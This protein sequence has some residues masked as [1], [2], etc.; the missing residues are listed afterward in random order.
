VWQGLRLAPDT[1]VDDAIAAYER[2]LPAGLQVNVQRSDVQHARVQRAVRPVVVALTAF[3]LAA[4]LAA[5]A[6]GALGI[7]RL[8]A[9]ARG[10]VRTL[11]ALGLRPA[12]SA[13]VL[14][15]GAVV[16]AIAGSSG[17]VALA[18]ALSPLGPVGPVRRVEPDRGLDLDPTV[19]LFGG[20]LLVAVLALVALVAARQ[21]VAV[22]RIDQEAAARPSRFVTRFAALGF[23]PAAVVGARHAL[24]DGRRG[25]PPARSTIAACTVAVAAI[26]ASLT[27]GASVRSLLETPAHYGWA[28]SVAVQSGGGYD[29][30]SLRAAPEVARLE[31]IEGITIAGFAPIDV[32]GDRI[33]AIGIVPVEGDPA[34]S[35]VRGR[36]PRTGHEVALG[37]STAR[38][39]GVGVG[40]EIPA[41][42]GRLRVTGIVALPAIG[43]LA[44]AHPSLGQGALLTL[45][46]LTA[47]DASTYPSLAFL[48]LADGRDPLGSGRSTV[49]AAYAALS[50]Y[51]AAGAE[52][53][54][55]MRPAEVLGLRP[56]SRTANLLAGLLAAAAILALALSLTASVRRRAATYAILSSLGFARREIRRTVRWHTNLVTSLALL[57]GLPAGAVAGRLAWTAFADQM[58]AAGGPRVPVLLLVGA[59]VALLVLANAI[60]EVP[61]RQASRRPVARLLATRAAS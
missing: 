36:I 43:P 14:G 31:G 6:L 29:E 58:G 61:A 25:G 38:T 8:V 48:E 41:R 28:A 51:P 45:D 3:G 24:G 55:V 49:G 42:H 59:A 1:R 4:G 7:L 23:G 47:Q 39:L 12:S 60:G 16:A 53:Y 32:H 20:G 17:A 26:A 57:V 54:P 33:N 21:A 9:A 35:V 2:L 27:F 44:S 46:G 50:G 30:V 18:F 13:L 34:I 11:R 10:D 15:I 40:D 5:L 56:A 19:L 52:A 37:A 22:E